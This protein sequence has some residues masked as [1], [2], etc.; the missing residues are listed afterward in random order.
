MSLNAFAMNV[1]FKISLSFSTFR[2]W[3]LML[4]TKKY[5]PLN[6]QNLNSVQVSLYIDIE[7]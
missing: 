7:T 3:E 4:E 5:P 6:Y 1:K 2:F